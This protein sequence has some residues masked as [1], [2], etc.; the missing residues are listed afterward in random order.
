MHQACPDADIVAWRV[1]GS[2]GSIVESELV[3]TLTN[4]AELVRRQAAG[5]PGGLTLDV[6]SLSMGYYHETPEDGLFDPTLYEILASMGRSGTIVTCSAGNDATER[7]MFP[8][9]FA[10]WGSEQSPVTLD[11]EAPPIVTV[12]ARNPNGVTVALFSNSGPWVSAWAAG[13]SVLSTMPAFQGG[14][15]P[16]ARTSA[17]GQVR[18][19][20]DPDDFRG[21]FAIWSGTSFAA[22]LIAGALASALLAALPMPGVG[23]TDV[24][25]VD[26]ARDAIRKVIAAVP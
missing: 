15:L 2:D 16:S 7:P 8:A 20:I 26:R 19:S 14:A 1:V 5:E 13:A 21:N 17:D 22:P 24:E 9:A 3:S 12:G 10:P 25:A 11:P 6:L 18:E 23:T 4:I